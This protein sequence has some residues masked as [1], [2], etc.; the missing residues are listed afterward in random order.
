MARILLADA[1]YQAGD[2][3]DAIQEFEAAEGAASGLGLGDNQRFWA[4]DYLA[5]ALDAT[6]ASGRALEANA[7]AL[8]IAEK[9]GQRE[10][11]AYGLLRHAELRESLSEWDAAKADLAAAEALVGSGAEALTDVS[12]R[13]ALA[14]GAMAVMAGHPGEAEPIL[15]GVIR[16]GDV[17]KAQGVEI[18]ARILRALAALQ[19]GE[20][21]RGIRETRQVLSNPRA[22]APES[23]RARCVL[24]RCLLASGDFDE[25][26]REARAA[27]EQATKMG[28][29]MTA[30][31]AAS[32]LLALP[33]EKR[34]VDAERFRE[35]G[36][37]A[38]KLCESGVPEDRLGAY[39]KRVDLGWVFKVLD[40]S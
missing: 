2:I 36:R 35:E 3:G 31:E 18:P 38:L 40:G 25:A 5:E 22:I 12:L 15:R 34:P 29:A 17:S 4:L 11:R 21:A 20:G 19:Q 14:R 10:L 24:A 6:C 39:R 28:L 37:R 9:S 8:E 30:A 7:T 33:R 1:E 13:I 16:E 27:F 26:A 23:V 32:V